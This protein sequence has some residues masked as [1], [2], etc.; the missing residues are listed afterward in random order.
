[1]ENRISKTEKIS[2]IAT[3]I[4]LLAVVRCIS[5]VFRLEYYSATAL[6]YLTVKP[7]VTGA[8]VSAI[9]VF[10]MVVLSYF[11][12]YNMVTVLG[13]CTIAVMVWVKVSYGLE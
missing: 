1:M 13:V 11:R 7:F 3:I 8:L 12:K 10:A 2:R 4:I 5:E 6:N 9:G